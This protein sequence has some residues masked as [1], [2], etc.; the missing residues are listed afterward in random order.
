MPAE[1]I[2][3][4]M[5]FSSVYL[6]SIRSVSVRIEI[7]H[8]SFKLRSIMMAGMVTVLTLW[9]DL[10]PSALVALSLYLPSRLFPTFRSFSH[11]H[12]HSHSHLLPS[13]WASGSSQV[14]QDSMDAPFPLSMLVLDMPL[15]LAWHVSPVVPVFKAPKQTCK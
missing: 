14:V 9:R 5:S 1:T 7:E 2:H 15:F 10:F 6:I 8:K 12:S 13:F 11:S 4:T 3:R